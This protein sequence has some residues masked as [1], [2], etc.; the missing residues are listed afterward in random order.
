M[1]FIFQSAIEEKLILI[2]VDHICI[3]EIDDSIYNW[4]VYGITFRYHK[5]L[6][7]QTEC[8][9]SLEEILHRRFQVI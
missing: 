2:Q 4:I 3:L 5:V 7:V 9:L 8:K 1:A 6:S